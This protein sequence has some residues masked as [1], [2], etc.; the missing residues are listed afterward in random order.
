MDTNA[1]FLPDA[2]V[3]LGLPLEKWITIFI[4][5]SVLSRVFY[6]YL[7][8]NG[9]IDFTKTA[10][11]TSTANGRP[12]L[13]L[14]Q[15]LVGVALAMLLS[16]TLSASD[17]SL[18]NNDRSEDPINKIIVF[19]LIGV[20]VELVILLWRTCTAM[21]L[22][23]R[24]PSI[25]DLA[26]SNHNAAGREDGNNEECLV[27]WRFSWFLLFAGSTCLNNYCINRRDHNYEYFGPMRLT[28]LPRLHY[29]P[30]VFYLADEYDTH[31]CLRSIIETDKDTPVLR[32]AKN[33]QKN[34]LW[35]PNIQAT[36]EIGWGREWGCSKPTDK[37]KWNT[38]R[39]SISQCTSFLCPANTTAYKSSCLCYSSE[40]LARAAT[41]ECIEGELDLSRLKAN[42][43]FNQDQ[44]P[45]EDPTW[46]TLSR[47]GSCDG[48]VGNSMEPVYIQKV[49]LNGYRQ[50]SFGV[51]C[52]VLWLFLAVTLLRKRVSQE[53]RDSPSRNLW[54]RLYHMRTTFRGHHIYIGQQV[55]PPHGTRG[56]D[57]ELH[58]LVGIGRGDER[59]ER[60][61]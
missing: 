30:E 46:P 13:H 15:F 16:L 36:V 39:P 19:F 9:F 60:D 53:V 58:T 22:R 59:L 56:S 20:G 33:V 24:R 7:V 23:S 44:P 29:L 50:Q 47:Y 18:H 42:E 40:E 1:Y 2:S 17:I 10:R 12:R 51:V 3:L 54:A 26:P 49:K 14:F 25:S 21:Q 4:L 32:S 57:E 55:F 31:P 34:G 61:T 52:L 38:N 37:D 35:Q 48:A 6:F 45:W 43:T 8:V 28:R 27:N 41:W 11:S 5:V